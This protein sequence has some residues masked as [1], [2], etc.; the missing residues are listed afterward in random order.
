M[1]VPELVRQLCAALDDEA[2][3]CVHYGATSQDIVD[4]ALMLSL[5]DLCDLVDRRARDVVQRLAAHQARLHALER[6]GAA[7][8]LEWL[9]LPQVARGLAQLAADEWP[10]DE[11]SRDDQPSDEQSRD[12]SHSR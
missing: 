9:N 7:W 3:G 8:T 10:S 6:D 11:Q 5:R 4:S 12:D 1:P 2:A